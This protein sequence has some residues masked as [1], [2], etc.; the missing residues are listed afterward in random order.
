MKSWW[1]SYSFYLSLLHILYH[2]D[3]DVD[4]QERMSY[5]EFERYLEKNSAKEDS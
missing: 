5:V 2:F 4:E 3:I 1:I